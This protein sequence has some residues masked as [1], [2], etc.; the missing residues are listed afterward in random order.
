MKSGLLILGLVSVGA[1]FAGAAVADP[2]GRVGRISFLQGEVS[3]QPP[4]QDFWTDASVNFPVTAGEAFWT[5]DGGRAELQVGVVNAR[6]DSETELDMVALRYGEMRLALPQGSLNLQLR[7]DPA[8]GVT[9]ST[10]AGDVL[11]PGHGFYRIDVGAPPDDGSYPPVEIT[12]F[13]GE[14]EA[15]G[16]TGFTPVGRRQA[17]VLYAGAEPQ[18]QAAEDTA[19][20]DWARDRARLEATAAADGLPEAMTGADDLGLYGQFASSADYGMVW[21]P[22]DVLA[23][24]AP[25]RYGRWAY[26]APWGYTWIDE[27]PWGFA[28]FHYG[29]WALIDGR[30]G[31]VPGQATPEP[32]YAPALVAFIGGPSWGVDLG[33]GGGSALGWAPLAPDEV[34]RPSYEVSDAYLRR[35]NAANVSTTVINTITVNHETVNVYRNAAAATVV[36]TDAF[37]RGI[38]VREAV[39]AVPAEAIARAPAAKARARSTSASVGPSSR[40][41]E[42]MSRIRR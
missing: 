38:P 29:R 28:P 13:Q 31:W 23:D 3:F 42:T 22:N 27:A 20:D 32:V 24:W 1:V 14:A 4:E 11:L 37:S 12:V 2:P 30:W 35:V 40:S 18:L 15:P 39:L 8:G 26:V 41:S 34:Y 5:G 10:P 17:A 25:Y 36:R 16:P 7:G 21:Y 33:V 19:I 9:I 6:L